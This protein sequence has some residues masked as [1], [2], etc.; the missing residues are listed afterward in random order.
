M[1][2]YPLLKKKKPG[3][4]ETLEV[5]KIETLSSGLVKIKG[6]LK[7]ID[8]VKSPITETKCIGYNYSQ[9]AYRSAGVRR[10]K[11]SKKWRTYRTESK[12]TDFYI[13]DDTGK[14]KVN[15]KDISIQINVNRSEKKLSRTLLDVENLLLEDD[16]EYIITGTVVNKNNSVE[17]IKDEKDKELRVMDIAFYEFTFEDIPFMK[18]K[19]GFFIVFLVIGILCFVIYKSFSN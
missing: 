11:G 16:T 12:S 5:S 9:L 18:K 8:H 14:I 19:V 7:A 6:R 17:I 10:A 13:Q 15:A 2:L 4:I 3:L 1:L